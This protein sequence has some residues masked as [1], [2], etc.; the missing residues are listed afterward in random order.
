[1]RMQF[2]TRGVQDRLYTRRGNCIISGVLRILRS[3]PGQRR[4]EKNKKLEK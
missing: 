4:N 3:F 1:M 2:E